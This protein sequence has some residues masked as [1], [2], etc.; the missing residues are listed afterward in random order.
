MDQIPSGNQFTIASGGTLVTVVEVGG[1]LRALQVEGR[2]LLDGY[3]PEAMCD[4]ARGQSLL[5]WPNRVRDGAYSWQGQDYQLPLT[6]PTNSCAIHGLIRW[7]N[8]RCAEHSADAV[9]MTY[10]LPPQTGWPWGLDLALRYTVDPTGLTVTTSARNLSGSVAPFAAGAH[11]YL[12]AGTE[13]IDEASLSVPAASWLP[14]DTQQIP[15]GVEPVDG[16]AYDFRVPR[17]LGDTE[18]DYAYADLDRDSAGIFRAQ[19]R[20]EWTAEILD[21]PGLPLP[22]GVHRRR[23]AGRHAPPPRPG[24][25]TDDRTAQRPGHRYGHR[26]ARTG[27]DLDRHLGDPRGHV[28]RWR[29][30]AQAEPKEYQRSIQASNSARSGWSA[31]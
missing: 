28:V 15:T 23:A 20:A 25:G 1:A 11:P 21:G 9:L 16:T 4:G 26:G 30:A 10:R 6:E 22:G 8:W 3:P 7:C 31:R 18:I 5:P 2:Q 29:R 24:R 14:T 17:R 19:L 12:R 27:T 13:L